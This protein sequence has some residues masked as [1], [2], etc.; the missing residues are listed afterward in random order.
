MCTQLNLHAFSRQLIEIG[1][2]E[3]IRIPSPNTSPK[4][5]GYGGQIY[6]YTIQ[7][8]ACFRKPGGWKWPETSRIPPR[9]NPISFKNCPFLCDLETVLCEFMAGYQL[10]EQVAFQFHWGSYTVT[11]QG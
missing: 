9:R 1:K 2:G 6:V 3:G 11:C 5:H 7:A 4:Y 10:L 8:T